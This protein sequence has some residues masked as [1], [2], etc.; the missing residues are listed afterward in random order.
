METLKSFKQNL[1]F[2]YSALRSL[3]YFAESLPL[4]IIDS[5]LAKRTLSLGPVTA[6]QRKALIGTMKE[7]LEQDAEDMAKGYFPLEVLKPENPLQ[8]AKRFSKIIGDAVALSLRK[9]NKDHREFS[10]EAQSYL[11]DVPEYYRRNFHF[12]KD[13]YLSKDSALIYEHQVEML[14]KG[15]ADPMRRLLLAPMKQHFRMSQGK[16]LH[17]LE[18]GT[19]TGRLAK[20]V[21]LA[22]PEA[23]ITCLD[24]SYPYLKQAQQ[25]LKDEG[26]VNFV[27]GDAA[28]M[29]F[30]DQTFDGVISSFL[31]HELPLKERLKVF[32]ETKRLVKPGG[33]VGHVDSI[34]SLDESQHSWALDLFPTEFHEPFYKNYLENPLE[35]LFEA[36]WHMAPQKRIGFYSKAVWLTVPMDQ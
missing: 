30:A 12:Q 33:F 21:S 36:E 20:F 15:L 16:G 11:E 18:L 13:G 32:Q 29:P 19:G 23:K 22:F 4:P 24:L 31:F 17:F 34:Q 27:Q 1:F 35:S 14:F 28:Q 7:L 25:E 8:H 3:L 10:K 6:E 5:I 2:S 26:R 9:K